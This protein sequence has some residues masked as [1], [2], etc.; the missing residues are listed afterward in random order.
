M[1]GPSDDEGIAAVLGGAP[2]AHDLAGWAML[3]GDEG[4]AEVLGGAP[5][6]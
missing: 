1:R 6:A 4:I 2:V 5:E 3:R